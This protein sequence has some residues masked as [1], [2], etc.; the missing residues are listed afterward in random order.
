MMAWAPERIGGWEIRR[1]ATI[2]S[3][4]QQLIEVYPFSD[5]KEKKVIF[6][7]E[8]TEDKNDFGTSASAADNSTFIVKFKISFEQSIFGSATRWI[9]FAS[10]NEGKYYI[11]FAITV[12]G[13]IDR[14][15]IILHYNLA[16]EALGG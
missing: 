16:W 15:T 3:E 10:E 8:F 2:L 5:E 1:T 9:E 14:F 4:D 6:A 12:V 11:K 13:K 7:I